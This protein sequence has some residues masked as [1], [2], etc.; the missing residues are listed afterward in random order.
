MIDAHKL[1]MIPRGVEA[2]RQDS[3]RTKPCL[4]LPGATPL[5]W[6]PVGMAP[7]PP[8]S[9]LISAKPIPYSVLISLSQFCRLPYLSFFHLLCSPSTV[10]KLL[11]S[12]LFFSF[13]RFLRCNC[14]RV[15]LCTLCTLSLVW[16]LPSSF[17]LL[18][19]QPSAQSFAASKLPSVV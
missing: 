16:G 1:A 3:T 9:P 13:I 10:F 11:C 5:E 17:I 12:S 15:H 19:P 18:I 8:P 2:A 14:A 7:F 6:A 4:A